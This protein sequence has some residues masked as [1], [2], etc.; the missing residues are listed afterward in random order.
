MFL[1]SKNSQY[2]VFSMYAQNKTQRIG[3]LTCVGYF[4]NNIYKM[5]DLKQILYERLNWYR[6]TFL[7]IFPSDTKLFITFINEGNI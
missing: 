5:A 3:Y 6:S 1:L 2:H 4:V 7:E